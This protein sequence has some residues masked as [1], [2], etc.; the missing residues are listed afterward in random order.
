MTGDDG[1]VLDVFTMIKVLTY[2]LAKNLDKEDS[3]L[4]DQIVES[5]QSLTSSNDRYKLDRV[6]R[7]LL[8][9]PLRK[10]VFMK[11]PKEPIIVLIDGIDATFPSPNS[12]SSFLGA[13]R[14]DPQF[15]PKSLVADVFMSSEFLNQEKNAGFKIVLTCHQRSLLYAALEEERQRRERVSMERFAD[16][17]M[18]A[19]PENYSPHSLEN[20]NFKQ[21]YG[22]HRDD[23]EASIK[24]ELKIF[25]PDLKGKATLSWYT[26]NLFRAYEAS[27]DEFK[28]VKDLRSHLEREREYIKTEKNLRSILT[29]RYPEV[30]PNPTQV[31]RQLTSKITEVCPLLDSEELQAQVDFLLEEYN[32]SFDSDVNKFWDD[33]KHFLSDL[34]KSEVEPKMLVDKL[35]KRRTEL[36]KKGTRVVR[37][38][39]VSSANIEESSALS[40]DPSQSVIPISWQHTPE[41]TK[42]LDVTFDIESLSSADRSNVVFS[43]NLT[44]V[45]FQASADEWVSVFTSNCYSGESQYGVSSTYSCTFVLDI[46]RSWK[47]MGSIRVGFATEG[48]RHR[49]QNG[50]QNETS[51]GLGIHNKRNILKQ[52]YIQQTN[53][54]I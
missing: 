17:V 1:I 38:M 45:T 6:A 7:R 14:V 27:G 4:F 11:K 51:F 39:S 40:H 10:Y 35:K 13:D 47:S 16:V 36:E 44:S 37:K 21:L 3:Y 29:V 12:N 19:N 24:A 25:C 41:N 49:C 50:C 30:F 20:A 46:K 2:Q 54:E 42:K 26:E 52:Y 9:D 31:K 8:L 15:S 43:E 53:T 28:F 33:L 32:Q 18:I 22:F 23:I 5:A 48:F 34:K